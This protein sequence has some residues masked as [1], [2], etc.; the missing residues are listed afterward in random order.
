MNRSYVI[1]GIAIAAI[2]LVQ[3]RQRCQISSTR[4]HIETTIIMVIRII[5]M[6]VMAQPQQR[7]QLAI[8]QHQPQQPVA[9]N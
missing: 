1:S 4:S 2:A 8:A 6:V 9:D 5:I 7:Q 3:L